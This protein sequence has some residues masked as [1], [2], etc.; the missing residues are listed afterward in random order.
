MLDRTNERSD[1]PPQP[2]QRSRAPADFQEH[3]ARLDAA[4]LLVRIDREVNKDTEL[5]PLVRWQFQGGLDEDERR[6]FLF[7]NV[8]EPTDAASTV[9]RGRRAV[10]LG[11]NLCDRCQAA[12]SRDRHRLERG[13][14]T[15]GAAGHG[16]GAAPA[17][18]GD[19]RTICV[20]AGPGAAAGA[21]VD[22]GP[23]PRPSHRDAV[24]HQG[25][26]T[27]AQHGHL[28]RPAQ[29]Q[30]PAPGCGWH[31]A[32]AAPALAALAEI[33]RPRAADA[34]RHRARMRPSWC[35]PG[36][37]SS[38]STRT[39]WPS[40]AGLRACDPHREGGDHRRRGA[41]RRRDRDRGPD[42]S[43]P[44]GPEGRSASPAISRSKTSTCRCG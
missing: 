40:P 22:A 21:G 16:C 27:G 35:S 8:V 10:G 43:G 12:R 5:H 29:G 26:D 44:A 14:G 4:G 3:L 30:R 23:M 39:R 9:S 13:D 11:A 25:S 15:P 42:R 31:R 2:P 19:H 32:S 34:L 37:R 41:R 38:P 7:T 17:G 36:R 24:H 6:A 18:G 28:S 1:Q 20:R 33:P